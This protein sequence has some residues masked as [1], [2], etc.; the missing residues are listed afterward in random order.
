MIQLRRMEK[1]NKRELSIL[2]FVRKNKQASNAEIMEYLESIS[3]GAS[4]ITVI[5]SINE[6]IKSRAY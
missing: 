3:L 6:L 5:R 2:E 1:L 4:R